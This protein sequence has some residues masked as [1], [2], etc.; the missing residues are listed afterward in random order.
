MAVCAVCGK[1][2]LMGNRVTRRG[3]AKRKG[4]AGRKITGI[5][6]RAYR[7]NLQRIKIMD[8]GTP[9]RVLV[10]VSC[11]KAGKVQRAV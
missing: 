8:Q 10:C 1:G 2:P 11:L 4:G 6:R 7:P 3:A 5:A 9:R